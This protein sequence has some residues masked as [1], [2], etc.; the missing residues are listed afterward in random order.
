MKDKILTQLRKI[1]TDI[2]EEISY[3]YGN[4]PPPT[5]ISSL[6]D[7]EKEIRKTLL[8]VIMTMED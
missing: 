4:D 8:F 2:G 3:S 5:Y 1:L 6:R 7:A